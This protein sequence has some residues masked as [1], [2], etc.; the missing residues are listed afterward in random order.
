MS[1]WLQRN[2]VKPPEKAMHQE[3]I[4]A[5]KD[6]LAFF[7]REQAIEADAD[8]KFKL[9]K[10]IAEAKRMIELL[11]QE[12]DEMSRV[13]PASASQQPTAAPSNDRA[14]A[15]PPPVEEVKHAKTDRNRVNWVTMMEI[16]RH[17]GE[18]GGSDSRYN[19]IELIMRR[20]RG[21]GQT[22]S[23]VLE[24]LQDA[25]FLKT[26]VGGR[27]RVTDKGFNMIER[28]RP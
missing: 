27:V 5:W 9:E 7:R 12:Q 25:G 23:E 14:T 16:D 24:E 20:N 26:S 6:K 21:F 1:R 10:R 3:A 18:R 15:A 13:P 28:M 17:L 11:E 2:H 22:P 8:I 4:Q 19:V